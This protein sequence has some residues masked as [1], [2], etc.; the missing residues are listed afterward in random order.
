M[1]HILFVNPDGPL[2]VSTIN[3]LNTISP[4][5]KYSLITNYTLLDDLNSR[6]HLFYDISLLASSEYAFT[7]QDGDNYSPIQ[8][9]LQQRYAS[10]S[11]ILDFVYPII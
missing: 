11:D 10:T 8:L 7:C 5:T 1:S 4:Q 3:Q 2:W 6:P 9:F